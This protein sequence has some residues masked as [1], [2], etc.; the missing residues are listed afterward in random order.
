MWQAMLY[1]GAELELLLP[2]NA[3]V[4]EVGA[5][6][7][8]GGGLWPSKAFNWVAKYERQLLVPSWCER[9]SPLAQHFL[10]ASLEILSYE[11][12]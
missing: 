1:Y 3:P 6:T 8:L 9:P 11:S 12:S 4:L 2:S 10:G 5:E 7:T